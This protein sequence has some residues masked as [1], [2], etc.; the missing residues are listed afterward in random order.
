[1]QPEASTNRAHTAPA[2]SHRMT[3]KNVTRGK[4]D[5]PIRVVIFGVEGCGKSTFG[6]NA[7]KPIFLCAEDGTSHLDIARFPSPN[8][9]IDAME[10]IRVLT[11]EGHDFKTLVIDSLDWLEP[12]C[13][14]HVC[15]LQGKKSIEDFG[16]GKGY[17]AAVDQ[18]RAMLERLD[19]L[20]RS[21]KMHVVMVAHSIIRKVD[22]P[23]VG[24]FDRYQMKL[25]DK[26]AA[27]LREWVDAVLFARH[28]LKVIER[29]GKS[30]GMSSGSRLLHTTWT[31]AYDAKNRFDLPDTLPLS[32]EDFET[33]CKAHT[34]SDPAKL[35]AELAELLPR[36]D[37]ETRG[38]AE[39]YLGKAG[40]NA[41]KLAQLLD[42]VRSK[43]ALQ[44]G[45][46]A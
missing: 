41:A 27:V 46:G 3:L 36:L 34:P 43:V 13:W 17:I 22:D 11:H 15:Q 39:E 20:V 21:R 35:Q 40:D 38:K 31:A 2:G 25:H 45:E 42:R 30:R 24:A 19:L 14:H 8:S 26:S 44:G 6:A 9:W 10:A 29:N 7:P 4:Q 16:F 1:M 12:L 37:D 18:W 33:A 32:W 5:R 23:Q 28:E